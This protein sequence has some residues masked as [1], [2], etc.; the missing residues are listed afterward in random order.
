M[1]NDTQLDI[2]KDHDA[3]ISTDKQSKDSVVVASVVIASSWGTVI[4]QTT[5]PFPENITG[6][7]SV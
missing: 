4:T 3:F 5:S 1:S 2:L 7:T 6:L